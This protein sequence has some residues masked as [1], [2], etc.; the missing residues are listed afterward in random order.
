MGYE[1]GYKCICFLGYKGES[2][3]GGYLVNIFYSS[4]VSR[5][6]GKV[7]LVK[8]KIRCIIVCGKY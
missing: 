7:L 6:F 1:G 3:E 5:I 2:C 4:L 8:L